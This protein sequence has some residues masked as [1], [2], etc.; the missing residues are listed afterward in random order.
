MINAHPSVWENMYEVG[1]SVAQII[2]NMGEHHSWYSGYLLVLLLISIVSIISIIISIISIETYYLSLL[3]YYFYPFL[4][5][6]YYL[7][8]VLNM[9][10]HH[11]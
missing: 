11:P 5:E 8:V 4:L 7:L 10:E 9:D 2:L 6:N 1:G 3:S